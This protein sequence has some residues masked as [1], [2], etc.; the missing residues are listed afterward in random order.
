MQVKPGLSS[1]PDDPHEAAKSLDPLL[2]R[3]LSEVPK[4]LHSCTP[5]ALKATAGLRLLGQDKSD[6]ILDAVRVKLSNTGFPVAD[7]HPGDGVSLM[8]GRDEGVYGILQLSFH[9]HTHA[10]KSF[11]LLFIFT[12]THGNKYSMDNS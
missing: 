12:H 3:A 6:R 5:V 9:L 1:Y 2:N 8:D 4:H 11:N 7:I 10:R